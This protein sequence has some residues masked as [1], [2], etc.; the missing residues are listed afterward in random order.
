MVKIRHILLIF[1]LLIVNGFSN[2]TPTI[3][4]SFDG[5]RFDYLEKTNT[6]HF[7]SFIKKGVKAKSLIPVYPSYTFPNHYSIATGT[8]S[9]NHYLTGNHYY[10]KIH[11][12]RYTYYKRETVINPKFYKGEPIWVTAEKQGVKTASYFWVGS[13]APINGHKPSIVKDYDGKIPFENRVDSVIAWLKLPEKVRPKLVLC[14]FSEPDKSGHKHGP[15]SKKTIKAIKKSDKMLGRLIKG[16]E[17]NDIEANIILVSDHGMREISRRRVIVIDDYISDMSQVT[18]YDGGPILQI[19]SEDKNIY[20]QLK[21]I[22][23]LSV[24]SKENIPERYH[25]VNENTGDFLLVPDPGWLV[26]TQ[27]EFETTGMLNIKGMHGWDPADPQMHGIFFAN[28]PDI[29][30]GIEIDSFEN[31]Y[32]YGLISSLINIKPYSSAE[33]P[34]G[35]IINRDLIQRV[36]K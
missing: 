13:E 26:F 30:K 31:V 9:G 4:V 22:R 5:M 10:S 27:E 2:E 12:E 8:Y 15:D 23:H 19:D 35:A 29:K 24:Y 32:V 18:T 16:L 11:K 21:D 6:P 3:L 28:G 20:N 34:D 33:F 7:D 36:R 1:H 25:F 14:Y 17:K